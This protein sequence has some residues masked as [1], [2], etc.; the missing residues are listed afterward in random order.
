MA[1]L[2]G[3]TLADEIECLKREIRMREQVYPR[4][5]SNGK[6][7]PDKAEREIAVMKSALESLHRLQ[8]LER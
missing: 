2:L 8:G 5:V 7:K 3:I 6:M 4:W 1:D